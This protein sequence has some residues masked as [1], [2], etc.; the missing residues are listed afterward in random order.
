MSKIRTKSFVTGI[1]GFVGSWMA[2][3]LLK[4][5][6]LVY[7]LKRWRSPLD[8]LVDADILSHPNLKLIDGDL[9]DLLSLQT[10]LKDIQPDR[11]FSL[12]S[13]SY[14]PT[15]YLAPAD[16]LT[17]NV[18]GTCNL[19]EASRLINKPPKI[20]VV[21]S[22]EVYGNPKET[23]ITEE[24]SLNPIS[25]YAVSKCGQDRLGYMYAKTYNLP[26]M[27][28]RAFT[29]GGPRRGKVFFESAFTRQIAL[30]EKGLQEPVI[31]VGN[32]DSVRTYM[33]A[34][35]TIQA[36][37]LLTEK[38]IPGEVYN[39]GGNITKTVGEFLYDMIS[40]STKKDEIKILVEPTLLRPSDAT[41]Q[42]PDLTKIYGLGWRTKISHMDSFKDLLEYWRK[43]AV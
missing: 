28:T 12:A 37:I 6:D 27:I 33:D 22:S 4:R 39:I 41:L 34:R 14:V 19:L 26:I 30:I 2:E 1:T 13:Q 25:P 11:I 40:L 18:V 38:G 3:E 9:N 17:T 32:L 29:H 15:S 35:D 8:N 21:S 16:T 7:G 24:C 23:P 20:I 10:I 43:Y 5:G 36:Y 31:K 42:I